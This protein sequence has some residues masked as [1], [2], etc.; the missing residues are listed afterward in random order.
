MRTPQAVYRGWRVPDGVVVTVGSDPLS[1]APSQRVRYITQRFEWGYTGAGPA[2][3][4]L[5]IL[6][7]AL[8]DAAWS[9]TGAERRLALRWHGEFMWGEVYRWQEAWEITAQEVRDFV[10][11]C[12]AKEGRQHAADAERPE[13]VRR[14]GGAP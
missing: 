9:P 12:Q 2:Q 13:F 1:A 5:A 8:S 3:L 6:L 14:E 11:W 10:E 4:A 7:D